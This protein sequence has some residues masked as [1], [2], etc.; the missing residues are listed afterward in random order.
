MEKNLKI[1]FMGGNQAGI[2]GAL[3]ILATNNRIISAVSYSLELT[4]VLKLL[5]IP[6]CKTIKNK[7]FIKKLKESDV[8]LSVHGREVVKLDLLRL[9]KIGCINIHPYL[10]KYKGSNPVQRAL[11]DKEFKAS[12]GAHIMDEKIDNGKV[13]AEEFIDVSGM[14]SVDEIY[15]K[16][17]PVYSIVILK[18]LN[19]FCNQYGKQKK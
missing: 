10:Y 19:K 12:V 15:N 4:N 16:L 18:S 7:N 8:L 17:Y 14:N 3:T 11:K 6:V 13:L 9:P 1:C 2:I 5:H